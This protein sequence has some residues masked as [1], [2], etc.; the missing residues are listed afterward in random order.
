MLQYMSLQGTECHCLSELVT[1]LQLSHPSSCNVSCGGNSEQECGGSSAV[2]IV[3]AGKTE[4]NNFPY[5][6]CCRV[7]DWLD[8]VWWWLFASTRWNWS[9]SSGCSRCLRWFGQHTLV[10][11]LND[12]GA[13]CTESHLVGLKWQAEQFQILLNDVRPKTVC[14]TA[15]DTCYLFLGLKDMG[16]KVGFIAADNSQHLGI[17]EFT[18]KHMKSYT[19]KYLRCLP[20]ILVKTSGKWIQ[21]LNNFDKMFETDYWIFLL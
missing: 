4:M 19:Q 5:T 15:P 21:N 11:W 20:H 10:A 14:R 9:W 8:Q 13:V 2:T 1:D 18:S 6:F 3:V 17:K 12:G 16:D 7:W